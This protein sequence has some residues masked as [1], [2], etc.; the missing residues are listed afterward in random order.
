MQTPNI[1]PRISS[2]PPLTDSRRHPRYKVDV[3]IT[4]KTRTCGLLQGRTVDISESGVSA[5]LMIEAPL[6][7]VVDLTFSLPFGRVH[8][9]AIVR[10]RQAF[11][12]GFEFL[13]PTL[14]QE[15][16]RRTCN[17]NPEMFRAE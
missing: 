2:L 7:E 10:Q 8:T 15:T 11:R 4:V 5:L 6:A 16:I 3:D 13:D 12:Y 1:S 9:L 14:I 17:M